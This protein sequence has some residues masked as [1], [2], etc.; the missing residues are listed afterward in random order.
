MAKVYGNR[1]YIHIPSVMD[2]MGPDQTT[3]LMIYVLALLLSQPLSDKGDSN[4]KNYLEPQTTIY[5]FINGCFN[6]M[7]LNLSIG[8]GCFTKHPFSIFNPVFRV[9]GIA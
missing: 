4:H 5:R 9:P 8:N 3:T 2:P 1:S 7:I 6:W